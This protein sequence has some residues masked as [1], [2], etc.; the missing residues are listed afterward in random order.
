MYMQLLDFIGNWP[1][2]I[3]LESVMSYLQDC[4]QD[5]AVS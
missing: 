4:V 3:L 2:H 1:I 5:A